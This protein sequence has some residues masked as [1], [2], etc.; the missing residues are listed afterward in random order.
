MLICSGTW[1]KSS[2]ETKLSQEFLYS[3]TRQDKTGQRQERPL[4]L[5]LQALHHPVS[6]VVKWDLLDQTSRKA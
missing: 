5:L 4:V 3:K 6:D 1:Y 2:G